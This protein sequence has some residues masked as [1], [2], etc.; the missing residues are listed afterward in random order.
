MINILKKSNIK[1]LIFVF[2]LFLFL[3]LF[4]F[5][6]CF[7]LFLFYFCFCF[8]FVFVSF[9]WNYAIDIAKLDSSGRFLRN[10]AFY[11]VND[12]NI[13]NP[14][15]IGADGPVTYSIFPPLPNGL[16]FWEN[17]GTITGQPVEPS[18]MTSYIVTV[19]N[20]AGSVNVSVNLTVELRKT[21]K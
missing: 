12:Y 14:I 2:V 1:Y 15:S 11:V 6:F 4:C 5:C 17:N 7:V 20:P 9:E 19:S 16:T 18:E 21:I 10:P 8:V 3:F 13:W